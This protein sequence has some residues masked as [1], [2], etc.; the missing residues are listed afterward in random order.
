M[1]KS[2]ADYIAPLKFGSLALRQFASEAWMWDIGVGRE[3]ERCPKTTVVVEDLMRRLGN[4]GTHDVRTHE[5]G[6]TRSKQMQINMET[7]MTIEENSRE[8]A[9]PEKKRG[10]EKHNADKCWAAQPQVD[11]GRLSPSTIC[12]ATWCGK[13]KRYLGCRKG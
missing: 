3:V 2:I 9:A 7:R 6:T 11:H 5:V 10:E 8:Y 13:Q 12:R 1:A 4:C